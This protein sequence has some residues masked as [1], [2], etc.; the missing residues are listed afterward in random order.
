MSPSTPIYLV[1]PP[2]RTNIC[3]T[4]NELCRGC[5][6]SNL[7]KLAQMHWVCGDVL[8]SFGGGQGAFS[9]AGC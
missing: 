8:S 6:K 5:A 4:Y 3:V 7:A 9:G 1:K 2:I